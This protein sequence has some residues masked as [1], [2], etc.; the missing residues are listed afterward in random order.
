MRA[1]WLPATLLLLSISC[2]MWEPVKEA[3]AFSIDKS[4][5]K[6]AADRE[7]GLSV[8]DTIV[9]TSNRSWSVNVS[10]EDCQWLELG[11][12]ADLNVSG[13]SREVR[14]RVTF[15]DNKNEQPRSATLTFTTKD[16]KIEVPVVQSRIEYRL[17]PVGEAYFPDV[18]HLGG[19]YTIEVNSNTDWTVSIKP[20]STASA[21][22]SRT[23]GQ[24][25]GKIVVIIPENTTY[26]TKTLTV[27]VSAA[28]CKDVEFTFDQQ[29]SRPYVLLDKSLLDTSVVQ[30]IG[31][32]RK[33][34]FRTNVPW[35]LRSEG[36]ITMAVLPES[37]PAGLQT[38]RVR[39]DGN[40][41]YNLRRS[42][43]LI[44]E[45]EGGQGV[46]IPY[47]QEKLSVISLVFRTYPDEYSNDSGFRNWPFS[48]TLINNTN[49]QLYTTF[50][51]DF[52][53][54][55][56]W[57]GPSGNI[58][59]NQ[60]G[61]LLGNTTSGGFVD[62]P[63][64]EGK[65]L[66]KVEVFVGNE[67]QAVY[68]SIT[69]SD[70]KVLTG[71]EKALLDVNGSYKKH[72]PSVSIESELQEQPQSYSEWTLKDT[73]PGTSYRFAYTGQRIMIRWMTLT[74]E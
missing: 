65:T 29:S 51:G 43:S 69:D 74:Y 53:F 60:C 11:T 4:E 54:F 36:D 41:D 3:P 16:D 12:D 19:L 55:F 72:I 30:S 47:E 15:L 7:D 57:I 27:V 50:Y 37:G 52:P 58:C 33:L 61:F 1:G 34:T 20:G 25:R 70:D 14:L 21:D 46:T 23:D 10:G 13:E 35:T 17:K 32:W 26:Q 48:Q 38:I 49:D 42:G 28:G 45:P 62:L 67:S 5:V 64:I 40:P 24:G 56:H 59:Y 63:P 22:I 44:L 73:K 68:A 2:T 18:S 6:V 39:F 31:A 8:C 9:V 66:R 71:G